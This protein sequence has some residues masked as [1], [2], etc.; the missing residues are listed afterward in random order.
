MR[1]FQRKQRQHSAEIG[2]VLIESSPLRPVDPR[3]KL[4]LSVG[5]SL[6]VMLPILPLAMFLVVYALL[7]QWAKLAPYATQQLWRVKWL[8]VFLFVLNWWL[9]SRELAMTVT[10]RLTLL[11][12]TFTLFVLTTSINELRLTLEWL[13]LP[14]RYAFGLSLA[15]QSL[16]LLQGEL[17]TVREAQLSRGT[18]PDKTA[19]WRERLKGIRDLVSLTVPA[20]VLTTKRAWTMT[21]AAYAR[22]FE[23]PHRRPYR[24]LTMRSADWA[25]LVGILLVFGG[26]ILWARVLA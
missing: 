21:E 10:M 14:Y 5:A 2:S 8:L 1:W 4:L 22:G 13:R 25:W 3:I 6:V 18:L 19:T 9:V 17:Q 7:I 20:I 26:F 15:F 24:Q 11:I 23:A 12:S 16:T